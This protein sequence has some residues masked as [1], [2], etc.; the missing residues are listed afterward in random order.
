MSGKRFMVVVN[1]CGGTRHGLAVLEQVRPVFAG[2]GAELDVRVTE[3]SGHTTQIASTLKLAGYDGLCLIGGDGTVHEAVAG[4]MQRGEPISLPLGFIPAGTGNTLHLQVGC[5]SPLEAAQRILV[6][7]TCP[8]DAARVTMQDQV[9]YCVNMI[10]WG[11]IADINGTAERLRILGPP[12]YAVAALWRV[13]RPKRRRA[14]LVLDG[15][16]FDDEFLFVIA[17]NTKTTGSGMTL[18]PHAEIGDGKI[19]VVVLRNTSRVQMLKVFAK[20]FDGSHLSLS[21]IGYHQV[22]SFSIA[23]EGHDPL[24]LDGEIKGSAPLSVEMMPGALPVFA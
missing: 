18:A 7:R 24:D 3:Y 11:A 8:L 2:A 1:P 16:A 5:A 6:G 9:V 12:R 14:R 20:V 10:G 17:C 15:Q 21:C 19:D 23:C 22:S 13:V 4:L